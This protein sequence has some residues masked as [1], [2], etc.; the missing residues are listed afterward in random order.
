MELIDISVPVRPG[1]VTYPGDP[2]VIL[3]RV[4]SIADGA[5]HSLSRLDLGLHSGT[6]VDAPLHFIDGGAAPRP[7]RSTS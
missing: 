5:G 3:E 4:R 7:C 6:H 1:M 2:P